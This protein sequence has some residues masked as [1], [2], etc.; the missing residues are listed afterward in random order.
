M[1]CQT[2]RIIG[3]GESEVEWEVDRALDVGRSHCGT[4]CDNLS[5]INIVEIPLQTHRS[6]CGIDSLQAVDM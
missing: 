4:D 6:I 3:G 1:T 2:C 5:L